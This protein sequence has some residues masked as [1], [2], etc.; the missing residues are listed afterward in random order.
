MRKW[1]VCNLSVFR[2][3]YIPIVKKLPTSWPPIIGKFISSSI[4]FVYIYV[5]HGVQN[6]IMMWSLFNYISVTVESIG[7]AIG[8]TT[9]YQNFEVILSSH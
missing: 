8:N 9:R 2:Y 4:A 3:I 5:W 1:K 6:V 7:E